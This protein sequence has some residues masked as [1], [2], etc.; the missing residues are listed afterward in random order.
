MLHLVASSHN[1]LLK[2]T[3]FNTFAHKVIQQLSEIVS[4]EINLRLHFVQSNPSRL[5][6]W[7]QWRLMKNFTNCDFFMINDRQRNLEDLTNKKFVNLL[8]LG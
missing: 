5:Q 8:K 7:S 2:K 6:I 1:I 4:S 3:Y